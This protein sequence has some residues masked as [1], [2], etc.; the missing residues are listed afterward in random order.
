MV[1]EDFSNDAL[2]IGT[3]VGVF[4]RDADMTDWITFTNNMPNVMVTDLEIAYGVGKIRASTFGRGAWESDLYVAPGTFKVNLKD[5][6]K[7]GGDVEGGGSFKPGAKATLTAKPEQGYKFVGWYEN[8]T[9]VYDSLT[10]DLTVNENHNIIGKFSNPTSVESKLKSRIQLF[11]NPTK[12]LVEIT[13][14][15]ELRDEIQAIRAITMQGS[16][17][18]ESGIKPVDDHFSIDLSTH[19]DGLYLLTFYFASGEKVSYTLLIR[20]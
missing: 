7:Q 4:Y 13:M 17:V 2:Y 9:K 10:Y 3:D 19:A 6:P 5:V 11:P 1:Y 18:Y 15:K 20:K 14:D 12:G 16:L 8:G